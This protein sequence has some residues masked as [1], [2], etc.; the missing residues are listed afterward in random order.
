[1][2]T[3][4]GQI[5]FDI[6][7]IDKMVIAKNHPVLIFVKRNVILFGMNITFRIDIQKTLNNLSLIHGFDNLINIIGLDLKIAGSVR[8][9]S[10]H[11]AKLAKTVTTGRNHVN[12]FVKTM[13]HDPGFKAVDNLFT[14]ISSTPGT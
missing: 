10:H 6:F 14:V 9:D 3:V 2:I 1:M 4:K 8:V 5:I 12:L 13:M 7:G 11:R